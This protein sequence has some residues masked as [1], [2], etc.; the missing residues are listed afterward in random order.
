MQKFGEREK[1]TDLCEG[2]ASIP[3]VKTHR[4]AILAQENDQSKH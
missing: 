3:C 2:F 1:T 4:I